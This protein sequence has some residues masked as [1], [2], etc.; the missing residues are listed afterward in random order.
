MGQRELAKAADVADTY[1]LMLER[2]LDEG[3]AT[4]ERIKNPGIEHVAKLA[5]ALHVPVAWLAFGEGPD[6]FG[7]E[8]PSDAE[9]AS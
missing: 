4:N 1:V 9:R 7:D 8:E 5:A 6:P 2:S 3:R